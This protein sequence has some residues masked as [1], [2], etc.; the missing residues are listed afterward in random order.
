VTAK[1]TPTTDP[2]RNTA[3]PSPSEN[4]TV[5]ATATATV[6]EIEIEIEIGT[7]IKTGTIVTAHQNPPAAR[8]AP[9]LE[10]AARMCPHPAVT[11]N[12]TKN[13]IVTEMATTAVPSGPSP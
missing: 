10:R 8:E 12:G 9:T 6:I 1:S 3:A 13:G 4:P 5:N 11:A 7:R 2:A